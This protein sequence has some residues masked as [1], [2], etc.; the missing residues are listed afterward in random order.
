M[1]RRPRRPRFEDLLDNDGNVRIDGGDLNHPEV[2][3]TP[4]PIGRPLDSTQLVYEDIDPFIDFYLLDP[5]RLTQA[6]LLDLIKQ[7]CP[8]AASR[9]RH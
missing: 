8:C 1:T 9:P 7:H 4:A 2:E 3:E 5:R 6:V